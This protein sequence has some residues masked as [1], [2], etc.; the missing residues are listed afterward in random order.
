MI[1]KNLFIKTIFYIAVFS[2]F[3]SCA[4]IDE[5]S[6]SSVNSQT[7]IYSPN[8]LVD[9]SI[10]GATPPV[11][12]ALNTRK[13]SA[14]SVQSAGITPKIQQSNP[15]FSKKEP[16]YRP[17]LSTSLAKTKD[18]TQEQT[19]GPLFSVTDTTTTTSFKVFNVNNTAD[20]STIVTNRVYNG[21][22]C[23]IFI[24][25][26]DQSSVSQS[27]INE[28]GAFFDSTIYPAAQQNLTTF[29]DVDNNNKLIILLYDMGNSDVLGY[30]WNEDF[31]SSSIPYTNTADMIYINASLFKSLKASSD[32]NE[33]TSILNT[34]NDTVAHEL[35]HL[36]NFSAR[37]KSN[38]NVINSYETWIEEGIAEG[39]TP[40]LTGNSGS[41]L[42][43][44]LDNIFIKNG[45]GLFNWNDLGSDYVLS[46]TFFEY[47]RIQCNLD[48]SFYKSLMNNFNMGSSYIVVEDVVESANDNPFTDFDDAVLS[49]KIANFYNLGT[50]KYGYKNQ[51]SLPQLTSPTDSN[52]TLQAGGSGYFDSNL[53]DFTPTNVGDDVYYYRINYTP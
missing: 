8:K 17:S 13:S 29:Y 47:L 25:S 6:D 11:M 22:Y 42:F 26:L 38:S 52:V 27:D 34:I 18:I 36:L 35:Q 4:I 23:Y 45:L 48:I 15:L 32:V 21:T 28:V 12:I 2:C 49:Y 30:F 51:Y 19:S 33:Q 50:G 39:V 31:Y 40:L 9:L 41:Y 14:L 16:N 1:H 43:N 44:E 3:Y 37:I 10:N 24:N 7:F 20:F 46:F 53:S 5:D